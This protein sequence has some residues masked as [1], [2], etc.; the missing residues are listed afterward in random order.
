MAAMTSRA[1]QQYPLR[2]Y[3]IKQKHHLTWIMSPFLRSLE[4]CD[5]LPEAW[6]EELFLS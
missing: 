6:T 2:T 4:G 1:D 3:M 5:A